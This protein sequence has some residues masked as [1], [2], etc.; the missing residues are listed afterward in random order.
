MCCPPQGSEAKRRLRRELHM[1]PAIA[2]SMRVLGEALDGDDFQC[3]FRATRA[4]FDLVMRDD[5]WI[6]KELSSSIREA[7]TSRLRSGQGA[8]ASPSGLPGQG[9]QHHHAGVGP[10]QTQRESAR[11][12]N[13]RAPCETLQLT[14]RAERSVSSCKVGWRPPWV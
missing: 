7:N 6:F 9:S 12:V 3:G 8:Q 11:T 2:E 14:D 5:S 10:L 4:L 1:A 13:D